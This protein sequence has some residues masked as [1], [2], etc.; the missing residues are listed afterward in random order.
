M[1]TDET[2]V[3]EQLWFGP[4][5]GPLWRHVMDVLDMF[6]VL[7]RSYFE[8]PMDDRPDIELSLIRFAGFDANG[9]HAM[10]DV[11]RVLIELHGFYPESRVDLAG[12]GLDS[13]CPMDETYRR[14]LKLW[15]PFSGM[16]LVDAAT[17]LRVATA[18][19]VPFAATN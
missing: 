1:I 5:P 3:R 10:L 13:H 12:A 14:M 19:L 9:E 8:L 4:S 16:E 7:Q 2:Q 17:L 11:A 6:R 15:R 18:R